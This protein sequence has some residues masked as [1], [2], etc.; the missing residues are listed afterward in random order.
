[1]AKKYF[2]ILFLFFASFSC[3]NEEFVNGIFVTGDYTTVLHN[4]QGERANTINV[5]NFPDSSRI[6]YPTYWLSISD[7]YAVLYT[8]ADA[9][10][11][12]VG[13]YTLSP[14]LKVNTQEILEVEN[15]KLV[16]ARDI[17]A[18]TELIG[19]D[20]TKSVILNGRLEKK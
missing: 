6:S 3:K 19:V 2:V 4:W 7:K 8:Q 9:N 13:Y 1:M 16:Y 10:A 20:E 11:S 18:G 12:R 17:V 14:T 5:S 15:L